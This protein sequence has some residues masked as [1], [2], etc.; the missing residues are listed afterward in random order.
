MEAGGKELEVWKVDPSQPAVYTK[1]AQGL[2]EE[3]MI[4]HATHATHNDEFVEI[5]SGLE[6]PSQ[7]DAW[8]FVP[9][10]VVLQV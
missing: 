4:S 1:E 8:D 10:T 5:P 3:G 9:K 6:S 7:K 2:T